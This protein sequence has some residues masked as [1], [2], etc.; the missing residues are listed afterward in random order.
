MV[1]FVQLIIEGILATIGGLLRVRTVHG[2]R[3][4]VGPNPTR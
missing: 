4:S 3:F 1:N 2:R